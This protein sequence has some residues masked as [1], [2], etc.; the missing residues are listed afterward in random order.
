MENGLKCRIFT[1]DGER[2]NVQKNV[3][4]FFGG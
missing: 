2:K 3:V 4:T 1:P